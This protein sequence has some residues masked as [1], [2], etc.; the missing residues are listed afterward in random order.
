MSCHFIV[1][2]P[3]FIIYIHLFFASFKFDPDMIPLNTGIT[4]GSTLIPRPGRQYQVDSSKS[5][6]KLIARAQNWF[7]SGLKFWFG[8]LDF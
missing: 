1:K 4:A 3:I 5:N 2:T 7:K 6:L 8:L